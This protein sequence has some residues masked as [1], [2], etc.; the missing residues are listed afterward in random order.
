MT[1][2]Q[3]QAFNWGVGFLRVIHTHRL[4]GQK[5]SVLEDAIQ[6][7]T[8]L[9]LAASKY[10]CSRV[11][12]SD[13]NATAFCTIERLLTPEELRTAVYAHSMVEYVRYVGR[14]PKKGD[15]QETLQEAESK[16]ASKVN[17]LTGFATKHS[18]KS[19]RNPSETAK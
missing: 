9:D 3:E 4:S 7:Y 11:T 10:L 2:E 15:V 13:R 17:I 16:I 19:K 14:A 8:G 12:R 6:E 18:K 5:R 1:P